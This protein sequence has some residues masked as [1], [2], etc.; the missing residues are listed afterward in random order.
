LANTLKDFGFFTHFFITKFLGVNMEA[1]LLNADTLFNSAYKIF[2]AVTLIVAA[3]A[4]IPS[5]HAETKANSPTPLNGLLQSK[6][7]VVYKSPTCGCCGDWVDHM[8]EA[9]F[10]T[11]IQH[12]KDLNTIKDELGIAPVYQSCHTATLQDY[13]FEGHIPAE[14]VKHF[15]AEEPKNAIGLAVP[16]MP[17]GSP[18]M[19]FGGDNYRSYQ[20]LQLNK[21]GSSS[22]YSEVSGDKKITYR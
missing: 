14:V 17:L 1:R 7:L 13:L 10:S 11:K 18:G 20:V 6:P 9:G 21:D 15:L 19:D 12:P 5:V 16:G 3:L 8:S 4:H 2:L 22:V